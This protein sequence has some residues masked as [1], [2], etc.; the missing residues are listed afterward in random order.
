MAEPDRQ[1]ELEA[2]LGRLPSLNDLQADLRGMLLEHGTHPGGPAASLQERDG[3]RWTTLFDWSGN[4]QIKAGL[5][6]QQEEFLQRVDDN[7][8]R[9]FLLSLFSGAGRDFESLGLGALNRSVHHQ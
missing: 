8:R 1:P 7:L 2:I 6:P 3:V 9:E 4:R 5:T